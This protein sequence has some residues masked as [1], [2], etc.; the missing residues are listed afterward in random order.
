ML[1]CFLLSRRRHT[2]CALVTVVH[3]CALPI[4]LLEGAHL[5]AGLIHVDHE[6]GDA[7]VLGHVGCGAG[8]EDP[9]AGELRTGG[10]HLLAVDDPLVPVARGPAL[11]SEE[12]RGG[13]ARHSTY[14]SR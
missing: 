8:D 5:D 1:S 3:T 14:R 4:Y 12:R 6:V 10:P 7:L 13:K 11:R 9:P 2:R